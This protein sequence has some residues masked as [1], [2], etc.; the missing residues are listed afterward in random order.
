VTARHR[1]DAVALSPRVPSDRS[2]APAL[3]G[4]MEAIHATDDVVVLRMKR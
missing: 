2:L 1:I 4:R 3:G